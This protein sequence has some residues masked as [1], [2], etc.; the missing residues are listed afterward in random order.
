LQAVVVYALDNPQSVASIFGNALSV[1]ITVEEIERWPERVAAV[2][3]EQIMA[4]ARRVLRP[5]R[6]VTG[7]LLPA[8]EGS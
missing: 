8:E 7:Y 2:T 3:R 6:S 4:V 5:E 1:G